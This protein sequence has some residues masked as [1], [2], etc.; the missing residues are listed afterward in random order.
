[1]KRAYRTCSL[2]D[3]TAWSLKFKRHLHSHALMER[4]QSNLLAGIALAFEPARLRGHQH[5]RSCQK[6]VQLVQELATMLK[7]SHSIPMLTRSLPAQALQT[8]GRAQAGTGWR[9]CG[10]RVTAAQY[11]GRQLCA[12]RMQMCPRPAGSLVQLL[13]LQPEHPAVAGWHLQAL[14]PQGHLPSAPAPMP[15]MTQCIVGLCLMLAARQH[16][17]PLT[18]NLSRCKLLETS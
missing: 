18:G 15:S 7:R 5:I 11:S 10:G 2:A 3:T 16:F 1:M 6:L 9:R 13:Q 4:L 8:S 12:R 17:G 14:L